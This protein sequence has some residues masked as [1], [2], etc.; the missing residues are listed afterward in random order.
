MSVKQLIL[1]LSLFRPLI[2]QLFLGSQ[3]LMAP[4]YEEKSLVELGLD[5]K[6]TLF[7]N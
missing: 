1:C 7:V 2:T 6:S 4:T 5:S 3:D